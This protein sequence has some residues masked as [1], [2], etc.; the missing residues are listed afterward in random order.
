MPRPMNQQ[1]RTNAAYTGRKA[2]ITKQLFDNLPLPSQTDLQRKRINN[3]INQQPKDAWYARDFAQYVISQLSLPQVKKIKLGPL[4]RPITN[5]IINTNEFAYL[6][7]LSNA[8]KAK[9]NYRTFEDNYQPIIHRNL[10]VGEYIIRRRNENDVIPPNEAAERYS[11]TIKKIVAERMRTYKAIKIT[12]SFVFEIRRST[13]GELEI[14]TFTICPKARKILY[15][16]EMSNIIQELLTEI[17]TKTD[18]KD[19]VGS[20][21][22]IYSLTEIRILMSKYTALGGSY[23]ETPKAIAKH[24]CNYKHPDSSNNQCL[25]NAI[26]VGKLYPDLAKHTKFPGRATNFNKPI[27]QAEKEIKELKITFPI[28]PTHNL[29]IRKLEKHFDIRIAIYGYDTKEGIT[30]ERLP[31]DRTN[32][33]EFINLCLISD[34]KTYHY[35]TITHIHQFLNQGKYK[36][37]QKTCLYCLQKI[38]KEKYDSHISGICHSLSDVRTVLP[39]RSE[40]TTKRDASIIKFRNFK[41]QLKVPF[42]IIADFE[43]FLMK[44]LDTQT[45][46][47]LIEHIPNSFCFYIHSP[48]PE[49]ADKL[50]PGV[51]RFVLYRGDDTVD[52][53]INKILTV[54]FKIQQ[55]LKDTNMKMIALTKEQE[56]KHN[57]VNLCYLCE[58]GFTKDNYKVYDHCHLTGIYRGAACNRCN[59][60]FNYKNLKIPVIFHNAKRYDSNLILRHVKDTA[61]L[62]NLQVIAENYEQMKSI[63][64]SNLRIVDSIAFMS[65]SLDS[66]VQ[67]LRTDKNYKWN[68]LNTHMKGIS[69]EILQGKGVYPYEYVTSSKVFQEKSLPPHAAFNSTLRGSNITQEEYDYCLKC[70]DFLKC[71]EFGDY[72]DFYLKL[73][74]LLLAEVWSAFVDLSY[75]THGLDPSHCIS[76]PQ[77]S[78]QCMLKMTKIE[79]DAF[80]QQEPSLKHPEGINQSDMHFMIEKN[81]RGGISSVC[82]LRHVKSNDQ[83]KLMYLDAINL[84]GFVMLQKL[85][86]GDYKWELANWTIDEILQLDPNAERGY[87]FEVDIHTPIHLHTLLNDYPPAP[88]A[89]SISSILNTKK[90]GEDTKLLLTLRDKTKYLVHYRLLQFYIKLGLEVTKIHSVLSFKQ[91][92]IFQA[93]IQLNADLRAA[94]SLSD[95]KKAFYKFINNAIFG[96]TMESVRNRIDYKLVTDKE[97]HQ[98]LVNSP[99]LKSERSIKPDLIGV[100]MSKNKVVLDK[101]IGIGFSILDLSKLHMYNFYYNVMKK[102]YGDRVRLAYTDTDSL[103]LRIETKDVYADL[104]HPDLNSHFDFSNYP[105]SHPLYNTQNKG[106]VG[107]FKDEL[108][109]LC[110]EEFI[111]L[112]SKMYAF[113]YRKEGNN[114][115]LE[116][117]LDKKA[118]T[119]KGIP[120]S[121]LVKHVH[122]DTYFEALYNTDLEHMVQVNRIASRKHQLTT[123]H[124]KKKGLSSK[125]DKRVYNDNNPI[126]AFSYGYSP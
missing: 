50:F 69:Q 35:I 123:Y 13:T 67:D 106:V 38:P 36:N 58:E 9:I 16:G 6:A 24:T 47:I 39:V 30:I 15:I 82:G 5:N 83:Y 20:N 72:H 18:N 66:L 4:N 3:F 108:G 117:E 73:D 34:D 93:Y 31:D 126:E 59:V 107:K 105:K 78:W 7:N 17:K 77:F 99:R 81:L 80:Y 119:G 79:L 29:Y 43:C 89:A 2:R 71:V 65:G 87:F 11:Y 8:V 40:D 12:L 114:L 62:Y 109:G 96:K 103:V 45:G 118:K 120:R 41:F 64:F 125:D 92:H 52:V 100:E 22:I 94:N 68:I 26:I 19:L 115:E 27:K 55:F 124:G 91:E 54:G 75:E 28:A 37:A 116:S 33:D 90:T 1:D 101:P 104:A 113:Q 32:P 42:S 102:H 121:Q 44:V 56:E 98:K 85:P 48:F 111:A 110:M 51:Q 88:E 21:W 63:S 84:Y 61:A 74:V 23:I 122:F 49:L 70:W 57:A 53:F 46:K 60:N 112:R 76:L 97:V 86:K 10:M 25:L 14:E 95:F